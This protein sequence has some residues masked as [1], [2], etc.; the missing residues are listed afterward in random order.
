MQNC[1]ENLLK[2]KT[3][4]LMA[5]K[6]TCPPDHAYICNIVHPLVMCYISHMYFLTR[7]SA[8]GW[9]REAPQQLT[10]IAVVLQSKNIFKIL[11]PTNWHFKIDRAWNADIIS[12]RHSENH[13]IPPT[14][15]LVMFWK[16]KKKSRSN[17][18]FPQHPWEVRLLLQTADVPTSLVS[19]AS[20]TKIRRRGP[21]KR[22]GLRA[23]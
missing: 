4:S 7:S 16:K 10:S 14:T 8:G 6:H 18:A 17:T 3:N 1:V 5:L 15:R 2:I 22:P 23:G 19:V 13:L 9:G 20:Q 11:L 12:T 21:P